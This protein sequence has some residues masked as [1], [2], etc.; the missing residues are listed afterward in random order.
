LQ[1]GISCVQCHFDLVSGTGS[2]DRAACR[3]CHA[4]AGLSTRG[5]DE[6]KADDVHAAHATAA[7]DRCHT[8]VEHRVGSLAAAL[9]LECET[10]HAP[11]DPSLVGPRDPGVHRAQQLLYAGLLDE[12]GVEPA[13]KFVARVACDAC[14]SPG[15]TELAAG[16]DRAHAIEG[17]CLSCHGDSFAGLADVWARGML[18]RTETVGRWVGRAAAD[19]AIRANAAADSLAKSAVATWESVRDANGIHNLPAADALL[20]RSVARA[21]DAYVAARRDAPARP[22]LGPDPAVVTCVRCHYGVEETLTSVASEVFDH[23]VHVFDA[24]IACERCHSSADL[25]QADGRTRHADHGRTNVAP[26][27][28]RSCHHSSATISTCSQCHAPD[29]LA[30][31][32]VANVTVAVESRTPRTRPVTWSHA[33]HASVSCASCHDGAH[34]WRATADAQ[35]CRGCHESHHEEGRSCATCHDVSGDAHATVADP[36]VACDRCHDRGTVAQLV[37]DGGFCRTCH[38]VE[39]S[40][41]VDSGKSCTTCHFLEPS[42][43]F[44]RSLVAGG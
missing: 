31:K 29:E 18:D 15:T 14:H 21:E 38:T 16:Y 35:S 11:G 41:Q 7:C 28:C 17:Q 13:K 1:R 40:H 34:A 42:H 24:E 43:A 36:H 27:D 20:R 5:L 23:R 32:Q 19:P 3:T 6:P 12:E 8:P 44:R 25:F 4:S 39:A 37:P 2:V 9:V 22:E 10:C 30:R 26:A 33:A